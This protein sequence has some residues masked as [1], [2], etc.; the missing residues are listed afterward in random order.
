MLAHAD[1][2]EP[3]VYPLGFDIDEIDVVGLVGVG[4]GGDS[5]G[6]AGEGEL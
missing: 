5:E 1:A 4:A 6:F 3:A 2:M